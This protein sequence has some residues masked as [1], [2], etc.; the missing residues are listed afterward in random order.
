MA[1]DI[2]EVMFHSSSRNAFTLIELLV[3][4]AIIAILSVVVILTLNPAE[5]L[6]QSRDSDRL[7][8]MQTLNTA[9][10]L[11]GVNG[12]S[13]GTPNTIYVSVPDLSLS[14]NATSTC[15][16][17]GLPPLSSPWSY[18]CVSATNSRNTNGTG[19]IPIAFSTI[20]SGA[21]I[22]SLALDAVNNTSTY[23]FFSYATDGSRYELTSHEESQKYIPSQ[24]TDGGQYSD[25]QENGTN[26]KLIPVDLGGG[27]VYVIVDRS[28]PYNDESVMDFN[29]SGTLIS[30]FGSNELF[31]GAASDLTTAVNGNIYVSS[32]GYDAVL[33]YDPNGKYLFQF[34]NINMTTPRGIA[35][36]SNGKVYLADEDSYEIFSFDP[37]GSFLSGFGSYGTG[38]GQFKGAKGIAIDPSGNLYISDVVNNR[39]QKFSANGTYISQFGSSGTANGQFNAPDG[40][41]LDSAGNIYVVDTGNNRVEEFAPDGTYVS[42]FGSSGSGNGQFNQPQGIAID[43]GGKIYVTDYGNNRVEI[44]SSTSTHPYSSQFGTSGSSFGIAIQK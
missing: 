17:L 21:P 3:V 25:L 5:L 42:Q 19:W 4:I 31:S 29:A 44:F 22:S 6:K 16:S 41:A 8:N 39:V 26:Q 32:V 15:S 40:I 27:N 18:Q 2:I 7:A 30:R 28:S 38:N 10:G 36:A 9:V 35:I 23:L 1:R 43:Q 12:V 20:P 13:L 33:V 37:N 34:T 14:G 11:A 24:W